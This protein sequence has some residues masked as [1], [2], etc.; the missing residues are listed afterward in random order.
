MIH[1]QIFLVAGVSF[2]KTDIRLRSKFAFSRDQ[3][4]SIY[5]AAKADCLQH[6]FILSTCNRTEIYAL[7]PCKYVLYSLFQ[8]YANTSAEEVS[9]YVYIKEGSDA[10][11]HFLS[12]AS[13]MDSQIPGDYEVISQI[14]SAFQLAKSHQRT[15]G[16]LERLFNFGIQASKEVKAK[17]SFSNGTVSTIYVTAKRLSK[18]KDI[19]KVVVLGAGNAG[20]QAIG[21][22]KKLMPDVRILLINRGIGKMAS[23][24]SMFGIQGAPLENIQEELRDADA[25][26]VATNADIPLVKRTHI[27]GS[28]VK[29]IFDLSVPQNVAAD[30]RVMDQISYYN[31]DSIS[32]LTDATIQKRLAEIPKVKGIVKSYETK[33]SEWSVRHH[34]FSLATQATVAGRLLSRKEL[35]G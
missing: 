24:V 4:S 20:Q 11:R 35:T 21:Y 18:Q 6:Y 10:V 8:Q 27:V 15:N 32:T 1:S 23:V 22:L 25:M 16:Y 31:I 33:F 14:K 5:A 34:Y 3:C 2:K 29:S 26:I 30:V 19:H 28:S 12:V 17:T 13:G 7:A 9:Q